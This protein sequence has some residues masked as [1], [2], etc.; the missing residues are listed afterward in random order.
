[1]RISNAKFY[2]KYLKDVDGLKVPEVNSQNKHV[3]N[4]YTLRVSNGLRDDL[5]KFLA[6]KISVMQYITH[7]PFI[8]NL[9]FLT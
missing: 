1:M 3:F 5:Q 4:Q 7:Y 6:K 8:Y 9:V 2:N